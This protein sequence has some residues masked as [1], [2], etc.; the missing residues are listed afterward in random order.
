MMPKLLPKRRARPKREI[1]S[2]CPRL[3]IMSIP[4][5][6]VYS[7]M[8]EEDHLQASS[9]S[10]ENILNGAFDDN[11]D[12]IVK[13]VQLYK[14]KLEKAGFTPQ[15]KRLLPLKDRLEDYG[16]IKPSSHSAKSVINKLKKLNLQLSEVEKTFRQ[17]GDLIVQRAKESDS[18]FI[19]IA[20][21]FQMVL[22][23]QSKGYVN[24]T[25][26]SNIL[27]DQY[28]EVL[29]REKD[30]QVAYSRIAKILK[31]EKDQMK[32]N[33]HNNNHAINKERLAAEHQLIILAEEK[34]KSYNKSELLKCFV[35]WILEVQRN[36]NQL[37]RTS[38]DFYN[39]THTKECS[40]AYASVNNLS[41]GY[42]SKSAP[43]LDSDDNG[44]FRYKNS[45]IWG[46]EEGKMFNSENSSGKKANNESLNIKS[47]SA[48][49]RSKGVS[50]NT[51]T[52][53]GESIPLTNAQQQPDHPTTSKSTHFKNYPIG[54]KIVDENDPRF[55]ESS[56]SWRNAEQKTY[57]NLNSYDE[58]MARNEMKEQE[59]LSSFTQ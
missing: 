19:P 36:S 39:L 35:G 33:H 3:I 27:I 15:T 23:E 14:D 37:Y 25:K 42:K 38:Q 21:G 54:L 1:A 8:G 52:L 16:L 9:V 12:Q 31:E 40:I 4:N 57:Q 45:I 47:D 7:E 17:I 5:N 34:M 49:D 59:N 10:G 56:D 26:Q 22:S 43:I 24:I 18:D 44:Y 51:H 29:K 32:S 30:T 28:G 13:L 11:D 55:H 58:F 20:K 2:I 41:K 6:I 48:A 50:S 46:L 53:T